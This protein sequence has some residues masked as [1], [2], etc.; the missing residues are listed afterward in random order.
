MSYYHS[1]S[2]DRIAEEDEEDED[3]T[4]QTNS[5]AAATKGS[6]DTASPVKKGQKEVTILESQLEDKDEDEEIEEFS[7]DDENAEVGK[8]FLF[9]FD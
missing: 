6:K 7:D 3:G 9:W 2:E 5:K 1:F 4:S 8:D